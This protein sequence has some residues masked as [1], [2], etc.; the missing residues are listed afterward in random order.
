[1]QNNNKNAALKNM[2][3]VVFYFNRNIKI[4]FMCVE[5]STG[6][7]AFISKYTNGVQNFKK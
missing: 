3:F 2:A 5:L 7:N 1:M 6:E 4:L